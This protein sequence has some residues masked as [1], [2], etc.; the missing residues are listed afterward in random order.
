MTLTPAMQ[1]YWDIKDKYSDA[2]L[3][4]RMG[5]FY[6][7]FEDDAKIAHKI[8]WIAL[9]TRNKNAENPTLLAWIPYHAKEK[10][11]PLLIAAGYKVAIA[12]Q[13]SDPKAK[14]IVER[15][16]ERVVTPATVSLE[17]ECYEDTENSNTIVSIVSGKWNYAL[18]VFD[19]SKSEWKCSEF[20]NFDLCAQQLYK[21][22]AS[23]V[24]LEKE[25]YDDMRIQ[26]ILIKKYGLNIYYYTP[27]ENA[28]KKLTAHF[29]TVNLI[30]FWIEEK[31]LAQR[32]S[33]MLLE[34]LQA[35]QNHD[36]KHANK[37]SYE[38]YNWYMQLDE[39]TIRSLDLVYNM[40]TW[41]KT[42]GTLFWVL[43]HTKTS[44][45]KRLL[46]NE[47]LHPLQDINQIK[48]RQEF[49]SLL[50]SDTI[51]LEKIQKKLRH[52][53]DLDIFLSR[54]SL[55]RVWPKDLVMLKKSLISIR[56]VID[57]IKESGSDKLSKLFSV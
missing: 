29:W 1:Q 3:F 56:E 20:E 50:K 32:A 30:G 46:R 26:E 12:E 22:F 52:V 21:T 28:Y 53:I 51:L 6:E 17:W 36:M 10:Y 48:E 54:L 31:N 8:L 19:V 9:T 7:M 2:I 25:M 23:E 45:G 18:S 38:S 39:S 24:I 44:M 33:A 11:L 47:I 40:A 55:E 34:Y 42:Q 43:D 16:V 14:W 27:T 49:I 35:N 4:F 5:D 41:S 13:V 37:L 15:Q 57:L